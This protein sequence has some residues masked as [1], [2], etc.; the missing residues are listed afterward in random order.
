[1]SGPLLDTRL[2]DTRLLGIRLRQPDAR[3]CG[4]AVLVAARMLRDP[5][6]A[7]LAGPRFAEA[8]LAMHRR[9]TGPVDVLGAWQ[10]PWPRAFG[11]PPWAVARQLSW[12]F[13]TP[14]A[15]RRVRRSA[16]GRRAAVALLEAATAEG[17]P[18]ALYVGSAW[19]P[20]HVTLVVGSGLATYEPSSGRVVPVDATDFTHATL[21][22]AGWR[23][24]WFVVFPRNTVPSR[25]SSR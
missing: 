17:L 16:A 25:A 3:S 1:M 10:P 19:L 15:V 14:Y 5:A 7:R 11:T 2:L 18:A 21:D 20:R 24:P 9:V 8:C 4:A 23:Q 22:L 12:T 6:Y 13:A